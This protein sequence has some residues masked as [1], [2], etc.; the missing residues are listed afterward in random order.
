MHSRTPGPAASARGPDR[1]TVLKIAGG[2]VLALP[3]AACAGNSADPNTVRISYQQFGSGTIMRDYLTGVIQTYTSDHPEVTVEL[4]P[5]VA[6]EEDYFTKSELMMSSA[7]TTPDL[8]YEDTFILQSDVAAGYLRPVGDYIEGWDLW[9]HFYQPAKDAVTAEN[10]DL[11]A[12]PTHTDTRALWYNRRLLEEAGFPHPWEPGSWQELL[13]ALRAVQSTHPDVVP[14][15]VYSGKPQGEKASMQG[16]EM[17]LY[18]TPDR[19]YDQEEKAWIVGSQGFIDSLEMIR[20]LFT[21]ELAPALNRALDPN[22]SELVANTWMP[23]E[24]IAVVLDGSWI[25][26]PWASGGASPWPEWEEVLDVAP[27]PTQEG[28]DPGVVTLAGGWSWAI[29]DLSPRPDLAWSFLTE[30]LT[31]ENMAAL[32]ATD[33]QVTIRED[34]AQHPDYQGYS[35]TIDFFTDLVEDAE[36]RPAYAAYPQ[37]S[38][39]IQAAMETVMTGQGTPEQAAQSYDAAVREIVGAENTIEA[40][41]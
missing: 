20:T 7:R 30:M 26:A 3:I 41:R 14:I 39:Q 21:E 38:A 4:V 8:V 35:P 32:A 10:G 19:L 12:V 18:G 6:A 33:N 29:P 1:R 17:L 15:N 22:L 25:S 28:Q 23:E 31:T 2:S 16:F 11:Y 5:L 24:Q 34:V 27:M 9:Q 40:Q 37:I 36:Y 13:E